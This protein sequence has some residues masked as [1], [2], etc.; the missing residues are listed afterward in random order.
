MSAFSVGVQIAGGTGV[1]PM[2]QVVEAILKNSDDKTQ[3]SYPFA[4][5]S[6]KTIL[7]AFLLWVNTSK[8]RTNISYISSKKI[9][10]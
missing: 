5:G 1:T 7:L 2:L 8:K 4:F 10:L 6:M 3:V 9:D